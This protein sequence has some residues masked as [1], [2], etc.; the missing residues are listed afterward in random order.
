L[1]LAEKDLDLITIIPPALS[2]KRKSQ[3]GKREIETSKLKEAIINLIKIRKP[4]NSIPSY[5][6]L[7]KYFKEEMHINR[8]RTSIKKYFNE[9][10]KDKEI[11]EIITGKP[12]K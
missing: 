6:K 1:E 3:P 11:L 5:R 2:I 7:E 4:F 8:S 10:C 12:E 9:V